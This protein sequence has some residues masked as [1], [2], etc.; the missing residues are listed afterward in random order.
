MD[1]ID[2]SYAV[3]YSVGLSVVELPVVGW[4]QIGSDSKP[5]FWNVDNILTEDGG[6]VL[7]EE[8]GCILLEL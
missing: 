6:N 8:G 5:P 1:G 4:P 2:A 3:I 7:L